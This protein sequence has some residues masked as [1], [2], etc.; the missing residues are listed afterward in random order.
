V[1]SFDRI[2]GEV[3]PPPEWTVTASFDWRV[4]AAR[5]GDPPGYAY[6]YEWS[7]PVFDLR[8]D[9]SSRIGTTK[10]GF[11]IWRRYGRLRVQ[12]AGVRGLSA[13]FTNLTVTATEFVQVFDANVQA[14]RLTPPATTATTPSPLLFQLDSADVTNVFFPVIPTTP[15]VSQAALGEFSFRGNQ[16]GGGEGYP[17]RYYR[18]Q[19]RFRSFGETGLPVPPVPPPISPLRTYALSAAVY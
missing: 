15:G 9:L 19:L 14:Q 7:T 12:L 10:Q 4:A 16:L 3:P 17:V 6:E 13:D 5:P 18:L 1:D 2:R 11:P 8:P